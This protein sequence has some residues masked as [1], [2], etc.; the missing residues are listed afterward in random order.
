MASN[1]RFNKHGLN[2]SREKN[3]L[4]NKDPLAEWEQPTAYFVLALSLSTPFIYKYLIVIFIK[5]V[6]VLSYLKSY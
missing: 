2:K 1:P 6:N 5:I 4:N 3:S